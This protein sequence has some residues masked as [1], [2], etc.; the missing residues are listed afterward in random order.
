MDFTTLLVL[1]CKTTLWETTKEQPAGQTN[2]I[3][4]LD[5]ALV[6]TTQNEVIEHEILF[7]KP[8][9][10]KVSRFCENLFGIPQSKLDAD[11]ISFEE[12]Y[13]KLRVHYM[14]RDR[15]WAS[16]GHYEKYVLDK[17]CKALELEPLFTTSCLDIKH[18][19]G[20]MMGAESSDC[21]MLNDA[22]K[23]CDL[24]LTENSAYNAA[25]IFT[26]MARGLRPIVK[27]RIVVPTSQYRNVN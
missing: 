9:K 4:C 21:V 20:L 26:R 2:D 11:G 7:V 3:I 1:D 12:A 8:K 24:K 19:Y 27:T 22:I 14:S 15:L 6:D 16:W 18:L 10:S 17:Q 5:I 13:R 25:S 23:Q